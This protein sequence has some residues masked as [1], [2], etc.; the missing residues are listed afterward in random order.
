MKKFWNKETKNFISLVAG[1]ILTLVGLTG[2]VIL[3]SIPNK[4]IIVPIISL[5]LGFF[6][7]LMGGLRKWK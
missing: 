1:I 2:T 7:A 3:I 5:L 6:F 4:I